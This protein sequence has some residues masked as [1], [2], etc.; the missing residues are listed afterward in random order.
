MPNSEPA[1]Q[2]E[3]RQSTAGQHLTPPRL[4]SCVYR[5]ERL[6]DGTSRVWVET[7][8][9]GGTDRTE[10]KPPASVRAQNAIGFAWGYSGSGPTQL[11]LALLMDALSDREL[12][13]RHYLDF[14]RTHV[15]GWGDRWSI[16][17]DEIRLFVLKNATT[18]T[19]R[20]RFSPGSI[21]TTP[22]VMESVP[23]EDLRMALRR[24]LEGDWGHLDNHDWAANE[25]ALQCGSR[26]LSAYVASNGV[27]FWV[28]TEADRSSSTALLPDEY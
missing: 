1:R 19:S 4:G 16:T 27:K 13:L 12:A 7:K 17:A 22:G 25:E 15:A 24:H 9:P 11:A 6:N 5:G 8:R 26:L 23:A 10:F 3:G 21:Y 18:P 2:A 28:I 20:P 14:K